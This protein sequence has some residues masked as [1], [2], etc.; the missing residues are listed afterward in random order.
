MPSIDTDIWGAY[1]RGDESAFRA[2][3]DR[4]YDRLAAYGFKFTA[5]HQVIEESIQDLFLKLWRNRSSIG[6][7]ASVAFYLYK[8]FRRILTR[9]L[10]RLPA[11]VAFPGSEEN[12]I[13]ELSLGHDE[14]LMERERAASLKQR[15]D[16]ILATMTH[17][18]REA[19]YLKFY[20]ELSYEEIS[21][22]LGISQKG[23]YKLIYR[24]LDH[25]R[26]HLGPLAVLWLLL[27]FAA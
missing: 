23:T 27:S 8:A 20:E 12:L 17:R 19:V 5:D 24:A 9:R 25:L 1:R 7:T 16:A 6:D 18:Q 2:L 15:L 14:V 3:Y 11:I 13:F 4:F 10:Q 26:E 22:L 21:D